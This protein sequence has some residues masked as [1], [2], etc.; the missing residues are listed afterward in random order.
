MEEEGIKEDDEDESE[1]DEG[2]SSEGLGSQEDDETRPFILPALWTVNNFYP[3]MIARI[4]KELR[5]CYQSPNNIPICLLEKFEKFYSRKTANIG[6]YDA[7]LAARLRLPLTALHHQLA[8][9]LGLSVSQ[10]VPNA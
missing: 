7:M 6:M 9:F 5:D 4:F 10:I 1:D 3:K 2:T 8:N